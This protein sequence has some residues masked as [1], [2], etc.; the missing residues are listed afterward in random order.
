MFC[1]QLDNE[2]KWQS[3]YKTGCNARAFRRTVRRRQRWFRFTL[4][5]GGIV[6]KRNGGNFRP[7]QHCHLFNNVNND[8]S[9]DYQF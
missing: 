9:S 2:T 5:S 8:G 1:V 3:L 6:H 7:L 4:S